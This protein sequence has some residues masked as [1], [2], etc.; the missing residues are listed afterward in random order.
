MPAAV[1]RTIAGMFRSMLGEAA[2]LLCTVRCYRAHTASQPAMGV[3]AQHKREVRSSV[4]VFVLAQLHDLF[5]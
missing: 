3:T 1:A 4:A 5:V 2:V